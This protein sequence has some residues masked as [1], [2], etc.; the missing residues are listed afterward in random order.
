MLRSVAPRFLCL[1]AAAGLFG[2]C[3]TSKQDDLVTAIECNILSLCYQEN[4]RFGMVGDSWTDFG[5]GAQVQRDLHDWLIQDH[6]YRLTSVVLAGQTISGDLNTAR[7]FQ[8]VIEQAGPNLAYMLV[9]L[10]GNDM[11]DDIND[12]AVVDIT[13]VVNARLNAYES[14]LRSLVAQGDY[15]KQNRYGGQP[16]T[17][18][19]HG[20]DYANPALVSFCNVTAGGLSLAEKESRMQ[21]ILD[22]FNAR[23]IAIA[24]SMS[25]VYHLDLRATLGGPPTSNPTL[26]LDCIHPNEIGFRI[27]ASRYAGMLNLITQER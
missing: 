1:F 9:S 18:I 16:L 2:A 7:G 3:D 10:G 17:W 22:A 21:T 11:L 25:N 4:T 15:I 20:Y 19:I 14:N 27:I 26:K 5:Y 6:G 12:Y 23:Q 13:P 8:R 24:A